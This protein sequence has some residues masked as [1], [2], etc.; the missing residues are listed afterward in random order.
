MQFENKF[1]LELK[2]SLT[3]IEKADIV[4]HSS[5]TPNENAFA[6][7]F[8]QD[9]SFMS[10]IVNATS[11]Q[12]LIQAMNS[13]SDRLANIRELLKEIKKLEFN[14]NTIAVPQLGVRALFGVQFSS[15][16]SL[17]K[18]RVIFELE[19]SH[20]PYK[21][22]F[23]FENVYGRVTKSSVRK[24]VQEQLNERQSH[25]ASLT[26]LCHSLAFLCDQTL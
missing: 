4:F 26:D 14:Y 24:I 15:Y 6:Q 16:L 17:N 12:L 2:I 9:T 3:R 5:L 7:K 11:P 8:L 1:S 21:I 13:L 18:F 23:R 22:N 25:S 20:L 19:P 10:H